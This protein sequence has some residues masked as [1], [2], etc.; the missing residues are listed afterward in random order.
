MAYHPQNINY[1]KWTY[2]TEWYLLH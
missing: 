2:H 1:W